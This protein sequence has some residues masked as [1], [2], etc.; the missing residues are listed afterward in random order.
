KHDH[1]KISE[2]EEI[3]VTDDMRKRFEEIKNMP[4]DFG[5]VYTEYV[6]IDDTS[7]DISLPTNHPFNIVR[8]KEENEVQGQ[9]LT[10]TELENILLGQRLTDM[11]LMILEVKK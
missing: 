4:E 3:E 7:D 2:F 6:L 9:K 8:L 1:I 5:S 10:D 11:E